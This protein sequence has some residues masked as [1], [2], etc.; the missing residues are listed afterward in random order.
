[1]GRGIGTN[2]ANRASE[3]GGLTPTRSYA[4]P[5]LSSIAN[6]RRLPQGTLRKMEPHD[7]PGV[8][9]LV[10]LTMSLLFLFLVAYAAWIIGWWPITIIF[11]I[12]PFV[13]FAGA[14]SVARRFA[15]ETLA[16]E[17]PTEADGAKVASDSEMG[18]FLADA[19]DPRRTMMVAPLRKHLRDRIERN[20]EEEARACAA[21]FASSTPEEVDI[22][23]SD[24]TSL[25]GRVFRAVPT[26]SA[27]AGGNS[28][29]VIYAHDYKGSWEEGMP[30]VRHYVE[31]GFSI[32]LCDLRA[33]GRS[34]GDWI[35]L[36]FLDSLDLVA[37]ATW[38]K[39]EGAR[40]IVL[41]GSGMG[42]AAAILAAGEK[43]LPREVVAVVAENCYTDAW[44]AA[45]CLYHGIGLDVHPAMDLV[46][47][48]LRHHNGGYD[49]AAACPEEYLSDLRVPVLFLQSARDTLVPPYMSTLLW[50][51]ATE[52]SPDLPHEIESFDKAG[53]LTLALAEPEH[54]YR[55]VFNFLS[56]RV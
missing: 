31:A 49:I 16:P 19:E 35:G 5:T 50:R 11:C 52:V 32:V 56:R 53:H 9:P 51:K 27:A 45:V 15:H 43:S 2:G 55:T 3:Q 38:A 12:L 37:W 4:T 54:Y 6:V 14:Y 25:H 39:G 24:G 47:F 17:R 21:W 8:M 28:R 33:H 20:R 36:G 40:S 42:A 46:R 22:T 44:N 23:S 10:R 48:Y 18:G 30:L 7:K 13:G 34:A 26:G 29:W 41:H 1:M